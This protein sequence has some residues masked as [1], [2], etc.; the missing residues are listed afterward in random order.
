MWA[1]HESLPHKPQKAADAENM[2]EIKYAELV[3]FACHCCVS[4]A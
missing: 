2:K 1:A 3:D 4:L